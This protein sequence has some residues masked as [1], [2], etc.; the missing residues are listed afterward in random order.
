M[1][2]VHFTPDYVYA[3]VA[4]IVTEQSVYNYTW[5]EYEADVKEIKKIVS[6]LEMLGKK[7]TKITLPNGA[8]CD[9]DTKY[10]KRFPDDVTDRM[11]RRLK[12]GGDAIHI[13][14]NRLYIDVC[15]Y[16]MVLPKDIRSRYSNDNSLDVYVYFD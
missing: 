14:G 9:M 15:G 5:K 10:Y 16:E 6:A 2:K 12:L 11:Y 4:P 13:K 3:K 1:M 8:W 7:V